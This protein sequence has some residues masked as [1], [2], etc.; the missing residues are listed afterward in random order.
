[1]TPEELDRALELHKTCTPTEV[2]AKLSASRRRRRV[3][4]PDL[5]TVRRALGGSTFRRARTGTRGAQPKLAAVNLWSLDADRNKLAKTAR[6]KSE[7]HV[8]DIMKASGVD[9]SS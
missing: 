1:M 9:P 5:K 7:V 8:A 2:R 3:A 4:G 6:G